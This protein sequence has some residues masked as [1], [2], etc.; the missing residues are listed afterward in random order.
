MWHAW[1]K[2]GHKKTLK[3]TW[4]IYWTEW[5]IILKWTWCC[6]MD[7]KSPVWDLVED[8]FEH[9]LKLSWQEKSIK[10]E[11]DNLRMFYWTQQWS[12]GFLKAEKLLISSEATLSAR[13]SWKILFTEN[14]EL[15]QH[16]K[17]RISYVLQLWRYTLSSYSPPM[18]I[19]FI[20]ICSWAS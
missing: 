7:S 5:K 11:A 1:D 4:K 8:F 17:T 10:S 12:F 2:R 9:V 6:Q 13:N 19:L 20:Y 16:Y 3:T 15:K 18:V 14:Y